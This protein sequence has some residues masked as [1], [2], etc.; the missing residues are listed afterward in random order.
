[1]KK[2]LLEVF[3]KKQK[4]VVT[5]EKQ[6]QKH[7][8]KSTVDPEYLEY[9][10]VCK[11]SFNIVYVMAEVFK[12]SMFC[13]HILIAAIENLRQGK[14]RTKVAYRDARQCHTKEIYEQ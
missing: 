6:K 7:A 13:R 12:S 10:K 11:L 8:S 9:F 3:G 1:M 5:P 2:N 4:E 14:A